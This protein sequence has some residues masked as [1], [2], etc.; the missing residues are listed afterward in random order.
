MKY[1]IQE[2][3]SKQR[4]KTYK[5]QWLGYSYRDPETH[6]P[7]FKC[8][9]NLSGLP[10]EMLAKFRLLLNEGNAGIPGSPED[11]GKVQFLQ[12]TQ[13]GPEAVARH[14][15]G[16]LGLDDVL[17]GMP[18][19][20]SAIVMSLILDRVVQPFPHSRKSLFENLPGSA[21]ERV[22]GLDCSQLKL[23]HMYYALDHLLP[24]QDRIEQALFLRDAGKAPGGGN[25]SKMYLY[26]ITSSYFEGNSCALEAFGYNRDRK[27]GKK[28]IVIGMLT[29]HDGCPVSVEVFE[30]NTADQRTVMD[31]INGMKKK[32]GLEE[33]V[34]IGDRGMLTKARRNDL[35]DKE[36]EGVKYIT[37]LSRREFLTLVEDS[38]HPL[39]LSLFDRDNL[40]E[41]VHDGVKYVLS[42]NP[43]LEARNR[44]ER[45]GMLDKT[46][47]FL[48]GIQASVEKGRLRRKDCIAKRLYRKLDNWNCGRFFKVDYDEG[49]FEYSRLEEEIKA[50]SAMD[51]FYVFVTDMT[52][53]TAEETREEYRGLQRVEQV[54]R[55]MKC[56]ELFVRPIRLWNADR[57]KAHVFICMLS[58][59]VIWKARLLFRD[60]LKTEDEL[61]VSLRTLWEK[62]RKVEIG[63]IRIGDRELEQF[64]PASQEIKALL[65]AAGLSIST[66]EKRYLK[67]EK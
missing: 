36:Y 57:V 46:E 20:A 18:G 9:V 7:A 4:G 33:L 16:T 60:F 30:G 51:G 55:T 35:T 59:M 47:E 19:Q 50:Y 42:Y 49:R 40:A 54:F 23:A 56:T 32:F 29:R 63:R 34:F 28:Q 58:Y 2:F 45:E 43:D 62:L 11:A 44:K 10:E 26:D 17:E 64:S 22:C 12:S 25:A 21:L 14:I 3:T 24:Q 41:I 8:L 27:Q 53:L 5:Y 13:I 15:A 37:A 48:K 1:R 52:D 31:R 61:R 39:Q 67:E 65:N 66:L 6:K 38:S